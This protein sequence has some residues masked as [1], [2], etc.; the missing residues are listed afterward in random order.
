MHLV[1]SKIV[2]LKGIKWFNNFQEQQA[3]NHT[4]YN[5]AI[6]NELAVVD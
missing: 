4:P 3:N 2:V 6:D 1:V 5:E